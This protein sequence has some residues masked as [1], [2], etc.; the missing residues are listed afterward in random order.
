MI[1]AGLLFVVFAVLSTAGV[2]AAVYGLKRRLG[3]ALL[4]ALSSL[5]AFAALAAGV[6]WVVV[7]S[8]RV[9]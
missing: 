5:L 3:L 8:I 6:V 2:A 1:L 4:A 9:Q 7:T